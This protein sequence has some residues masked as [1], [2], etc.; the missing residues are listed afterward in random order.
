MNRFQQLMN[1]YAAYHTKNITK[2]THLIGITYIIIGLQVLFFIP[3][4][5]IMS[6]PVALAPVL[7]MFVSLYYF[8]LNAA[9]A[10]FTSLYLSILTML[11]YILYLYGTPVTMFA[12]LFVFGWLLQF[13]GH[14]FEGKKPAF[15]EDMRLSFVAPMFVVHEL[16][17]LII[18]KYDRV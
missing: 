10:L 2:F 6:Q 8:T 12:E 9:L 7:L 11:S 3:T 5:N 17:D 13:I 18:A 1:G 14:Y 15:L 16:K 4:I